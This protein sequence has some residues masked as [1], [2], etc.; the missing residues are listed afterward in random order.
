MTQKPNV[1][2]SDLQAIYVKV[3]WLI[4]DTSQADITCQMGRLA[5]EMQTMQRKKQLL[6]WT[7]TEIRYQIF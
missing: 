3:S 7:F 5:K 2:F 6:H 1:Q 4:K